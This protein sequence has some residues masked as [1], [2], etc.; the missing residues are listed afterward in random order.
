MQGKGFSLTST[1]EL[2][3]R[4]S[5]LSHWR[6]RSSKFGSQDIEHPQNSPRHCHTSVRMYGQLIPF[7]SF[8]DFKDDEGYGYILQ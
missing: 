6:S 8:T 7:K 3:H 1:V 5:I 4:V 2:Q